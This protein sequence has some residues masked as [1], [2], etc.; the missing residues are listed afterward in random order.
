MGYNRILM[1]VS[2]KVIKNCLGLLICSS[3]LINYYKKFQWKLIKLNLFKIID[4]PFS[5]NAML[6]NQQK[7]K[8]IGNKV[9]YFYI[10]K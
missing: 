7:I 2:E 9:I 4:H 3:N 1:K 10:N 6:F 5:T 8:K